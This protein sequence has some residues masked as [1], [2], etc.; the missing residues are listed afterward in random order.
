MVSA[1]KLAEINEMIKNGTLP[2]S[3][4]D[5]VAAHRQCNEMFPGKGVPKE[6]QR[7]YPLNSMG[8]SY[9][10]M[11]AA[12]NTAQR[13]MQQNRTQRLTRCYGDPNADRMSSINVRGCSQR[14]NYSV[15]FS[16]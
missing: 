2:S 6:F 5:S 15:C 8:I 1:V 11:E 4:F 16:L 9:E 3:F 10:E 7:H 14:V 12:R 13:I